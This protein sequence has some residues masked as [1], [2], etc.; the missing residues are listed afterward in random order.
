MRIFSR[1]S[2]PEEE[3][4]EAFIANAR[5]QFSKFL[6]W[7]Q[8]IGR[9]KVLM[10][11]SRRKRQKCREKS[12]HADERLS[13]SNAALIIIMGVNIWRRWEFFGFKPHSSENS[14][15]KCVQEVKAGEFFLLTF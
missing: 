11:I 5:I 12:K 4:K 15:G 6:F 2:L 10:I 8:Q 14:G 7:P 9:D 3:V 1:A 13:N